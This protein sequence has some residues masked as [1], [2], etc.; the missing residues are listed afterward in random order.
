VTGS[1]LNILEALLKAVPKKCYKTEDEVSLYAL[2][3]FL[4]P[5]ENSKKEV[6]VVRRPNFV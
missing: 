3:N 1:K 5:Q 2:T 6:I 4:C